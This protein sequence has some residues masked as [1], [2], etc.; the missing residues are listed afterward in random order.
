MKILKFI[1]ANA[2]SV[3]TLVFGLVC[4]L[5]FVAAEHWYIYVPA[6]LIGTVVI[7]VPVL[8][9]WE[10]IYNKMLNDDDRDKA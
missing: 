9:Y 8:E 4:T 3:M 7:T 10:G 6:F 2:L 1:G 5:V